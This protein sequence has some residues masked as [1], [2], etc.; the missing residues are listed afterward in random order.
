MLSPLGDGAKV[1]SGFLIR[2]R[3]ILYLNSCWH[4]FSGINPLRPAL[5][6]ARPQKVTSLE[7]L[8]VDAV[9]SNGGAS[10]TIG[11]RR[12]FRIELYDGDGTPRWEQGRLSNICPEIEIAGYRLPKHDIARIAIDEEKPHQSRYLEIPNAPYDDFVVPG[13]TLYVAGFPYGF[14]YSDKNQHAVVLTRHAASFQPVSE[15][16]L[17]DGPCS[18]GMSGGPVLIEASAGLS[19]VGVYTGL[20]YPEG[21]VESPNPNTALG[22]YCPYSPGSRIAI[23][24]IA[25]TPARDLVKNDGSS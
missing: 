16:S 6:G 22:T 3:G 15:S 24:L 14:S 23:D 8:Q 1:A 9:P 5:P 2:D 12:T 17:L 4:V 21:V 13:D 7:V 18:P 10:V 20:R 11:G 19:L 25:F